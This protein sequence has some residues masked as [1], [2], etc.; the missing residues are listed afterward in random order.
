MQPTVVRPRIVGSAL[1]R[2]RENLADE[3]TRL[4]GP[5]DTAMATPS[6][7]KEAA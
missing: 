2:P 7:G 1:F 5:A 6:H 4:R 3:V